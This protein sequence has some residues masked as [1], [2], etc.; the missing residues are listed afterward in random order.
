MAKYLDPKA[1]LTFKKI[2]G[3]HKNL[4]ISLLN[5]L[6]PL[7]EGM[8]IE[9]VEYLSPENVPTAPK[10]KYSIVDVKCIDNYKRH[11]IVEM[12]TYFTPA[13]FH[14]TLFNTTSVYSQQLVKGDAFDELKP[15]YALSLVDDL[16]FPDYNNEY[17]QTYQIVNTKHSEDTYDDIVLIFVE[18]P[19]FKPSDKAEERLKNLWLRFLTEIKDG[20]TSISQDLLAEDEI[21]EAVDIL[22]ESGYSPEEMEAYRQFWL[23]VSTERSAILDAKNEG[24]EEGIGIGR[25]QGADEKA[26][27]MALKMLKKGF[28]KD[29]IIDT[30]ELTPEQTTMFTNALDKQL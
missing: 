28:S 16:A 3:T 7:P 18:L 6:L 15:V 29:T 25:K 11:F 23:N 5:S 10:K 13:F 14:R 20:D 30:L 4:V 12:Q 2:F 19:K 27:E 8:K 1:D 9:S 26:I 24:I 17:Y 21:A 22:E